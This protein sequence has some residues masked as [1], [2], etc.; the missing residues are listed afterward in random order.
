MTFSK[1]AQK[2]CFYLIVVSL[3]LILSKL[4]KFIHSFISWQL[5]CPNE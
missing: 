1:F 4:K 5:P 2:M 3:Y